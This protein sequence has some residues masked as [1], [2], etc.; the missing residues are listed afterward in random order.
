MTKKKKPLTVD[1]IEK[2]I[3]IYKEAE[4]RVRLRTITEKEVKGNVTIFL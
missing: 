2:L 4:K 3:E 1:R